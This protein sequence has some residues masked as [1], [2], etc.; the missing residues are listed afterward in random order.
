MD[1]ITVLGVIASLIACLQFTGTLMKRFESSDHSK[2]DLYRILQTIQGF[3]DTCNDLKSRLDAHFE[4]EVRLSTYQHF[5]EPL[6]LCRKAL[7]FL[8]KKLDGLNFISQ[9]IVEN[10]WNSKLKKC[11]QRLNEVKDLLKLALCRNDS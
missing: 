11:L 5:D 7:K 10:R 6:R 2:P 8:H 3:Q 9:H 1:L 4:N